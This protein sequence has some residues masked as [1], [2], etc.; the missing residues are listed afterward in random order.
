MKFDNKYYNSQE[1][2]DYLRIK[3]KSLYNLKCMGRLVGHNAGGRK[4]G[5]L[6]FTKE[7]LDKFVRGELRLSDKSLE[8]SPVNS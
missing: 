8:N 1:A 4:G 3:K 6:L 5:K 2:A 7:E